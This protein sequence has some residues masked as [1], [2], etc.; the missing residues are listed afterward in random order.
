LGAECASPV[1]MLEK[2]LKAVL[3]ERAKLLTRVAPVP[4]LKIDAIAAQEAV[5]TAA[6]ELVL[7][8]QRSGCKLEDDEFMIEF[9]KKMAARDG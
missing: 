1:G 3:D 2:W 7:W 6:A 4:P 8:E 5:Y 9:I